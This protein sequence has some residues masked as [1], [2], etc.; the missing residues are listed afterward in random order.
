MGLTAKV[1]GNMAFTQLNRYFIK[2]HKDR[3]SSL[4]LG[5]GW[6]RRYSGWLTWDDILQRQR[7]VLLAEALSGKTEEFR[8]QAIA[9]R[10]QGIPAF[11]VRIDDLADEGVEAALDPADISV[12]QSWQRS[13]PASD[14]WFFLDSVDEAR[15]NNKSMSR[16]FRCLA[17]ELG[18][19]LG[20]SHILVSC[21]VSDWHGQQD[22]DE[23]QRLLPV[24]EVPESSDT[25]SDTA[26]LDPIL[27]RP[28]R[29]QPR[30]GDPVSE[31]GSS[32]PIVVRLIPLTSEQRR[33][34]A[35]SSGIDRPDSFAAAIEAQGLDLLAERPGDLLTLAD[36]WRDH[37]K[38]GSLSEMI[39]Y[40]VDHLLRE[41]D[42]HRAD[43]RDLDSQQA[44]I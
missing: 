20:R 39:A 21:R 35:A 15:L 3:E 40:G 22:I 30:V 13:E 25:D 42:C 37:E 26:L 34:L 8:Q 43:N 33:R 41:R 6:G 10:G 38:F 1:P 11:F 27:H 14:A 29:P 31:Q 18:D 9:L 4:N 23:L 36:Y 44:L 19:G 28:A 12:F 32:Q 5:L 17:R 24:R 16:A 7:V 2:I